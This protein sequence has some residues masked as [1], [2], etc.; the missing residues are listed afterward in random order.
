[1]V[2]VMYIPIGDALGWTERLTEKNLPV[3]YT[4]RDSS[5]KVRVVWDREG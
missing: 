2:E 4:T 5:M 1:M 3:V